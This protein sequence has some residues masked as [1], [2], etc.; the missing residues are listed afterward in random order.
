MLMV[1]VERPLLIHGSNKG[2]IK[3]KTPIPSLKKPQA[4]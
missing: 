1:E 3:S 4:L 2:K